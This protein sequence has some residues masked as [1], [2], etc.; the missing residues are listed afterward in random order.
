M[1]V[2]GQVESIPSFS[3]SYGVE[4]ASNLSTPQLSLM[5]GSIKT[6]RKLDPSYSLTFYLVIIMLH[7]EWVSRLVHVHQLPMSAILSPI[8]RLHM[9]SLHSV[10]N[11]HYPSEFLFKNASLKINLSVGF[12]LTIFCCMSSNIIVLPFLNFKIQILNQEHN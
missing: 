11:T 4:I 8:I 3:G 12:L 5:V 2:F 6:S 7:Y 1:C 10:K 9:W